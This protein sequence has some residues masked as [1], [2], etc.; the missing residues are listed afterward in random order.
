MVDCSIGPDLSFTQWIEMGRRLTRLK[1]RSAWSVGDWLVYGQRMFGNRYRIAL[2]ETD[3]RYQTLRNYAWVARRFPPP[4]RRE[5]LSF[6]HHAEVAGLPA[7]GQDLW[8][9]RAERYGWSRNEL[10]RRREAERE[11]GSAFE[12]LVAPTVLRLTVPATRLRAWRGAATDR[13]QEL[14]DWLTAVADAA[15]DGSAVGRVAR[16]L[17][18]QRD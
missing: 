18:R 5:Q 4:R 14:R 10:R 7:A 3:F 11:G 2:A 6:Q 12:M 8:L 17:S 15:A 9:N 1:N 16:P 13:G